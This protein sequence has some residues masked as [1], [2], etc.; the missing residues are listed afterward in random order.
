MNNPKNATAEQQQILEN[1]N[2]ILYTCRNTIGNFE[3]KEVIKSDGHYYRLRACNKRI[4]EFI[5]V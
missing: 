1:A 5:E 2:S 4:T 3:E